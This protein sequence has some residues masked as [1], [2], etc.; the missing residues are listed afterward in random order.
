MTVKRIFDVFF[1]SLA[2]VLLTPI[3][4]V[5]AVLIRVTSEGPVFFHSVR[6]GQNRRNGERRRNQTNWEN[7]RRKGERRKL[8]LPGRPFRM[9]KF[10]TMVPEAEKKGPALTLRNDPRV[11]K[12][13]NLLRKTKLDELPNLINVLKGEM[14]LIG[15]RPEVPSIVQHYTPEH[16][17]IFSVK[18][19]VVGINQ[20]LYRDEEDEY[21]ENVQDI[22]RFYIEQVLPQKLKNDLQYVKTRTFLG[23]LKLLI[24]GIFAT[25]MGFFKR[26]LLKESKSPG[27]LLPIDVVLVCLSY[28]LANNLRFDWAIPRNEYLIF[29]QSL[30]IVLGFRIV[31]F[32]YFGIYKS[33]WKYIGVQDLISII[34]ACVVSSVL[35]VVSIFF[36]DLSRGASRSIFIIDWVLTVFLIGGLRLS[37][38]IFTERTTIKDKIR[39]NV[40]II[41]AGDIGEMLLRELERNAKHEY[42]IVGFVDDNPQKL[43]KVIH[44]VK[45]WGSRE[46]IP[47]LASLLKVD[48]VFLAISKISSEEIRSILK[49]CEEA[50]VRYRIVPA[51]IDL[52]SGNVHL[53]KIRNVEIADL[54]GRKPIQLDFSAIREFILNKKVLVTGAGGSIGAELCRQIAEYEPQ[55]LVLVDR[56]ENYLHEIECEIKTNFPHLNAVFKLADIT[57]EKKQR[58]I[59]KLYTPEVIF[60]AAAQKHVPLGEENPEEAVKN[61]VLGTQIM[62]NLAH[63]FGVGHFVMVST[64]KAVNP[65]SVMGATKRTAELYIQS[66]A[67]ISKTR[68]VTVRFG[69]VMNSNGSVVPLFLKQ[70][71]KGGPVTVTHPEVERYFMSIPEAVQLILQAVTMGKN[72]EIFILDMGESIKIVD[73]ATELI[74]RSGLRPYKD[75]KI[76]FTGLRPGE[77]M[78]EELI[79]RGEEVLPTIH[80][81]IRTLK[82]NNVSELEG[83]EQKIRALM[84][85]TSRMN[86]AGIVKK[87]QE[88]VPEYRP[89]RSYSI[90]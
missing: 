33:L 77:K 76:K 20:I 37:L 4:A 28:F 75:V 87:L 26:G 7:D 68:F 19:G 49:Y 12:V 23:D 88:I 60:H 1:S 31:S 25:L 63:E 14:S 30:P 52:L 5:I 41:G 2:L 35:I 78:Y 80:N 86:Y 36:L 16:Q 56:N 85:L 57:D 18:P 73:L 72:G 39:K 70:I 71:E 38:R 17:E 66:L 53:S 6:I 40:L 69:N 13:G 74:K 79:A 42:N 84:R 50:N 58:K 82:T 89:A 43:G 54:F 27:L 29:I 44:G 81:H 90:P 62:A 34:K 22:E 8:N 3:F 47:Q 15:P 65:T 11:T 48:E 61:N 9:L 59:F 46:D 55:S 24:G 67:K 51:V 32:Y 83:I 45:V 64:D 21:P 10:R